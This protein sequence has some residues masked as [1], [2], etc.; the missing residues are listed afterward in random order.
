MFDEW[1]IRRLDLLLASS[2]ARLPEALW[3]MVS[4]AVG[5]VTSVV[6]ID[7]VMT[8]EWTKSDRYRREFRKINVIITNTLSKAN[9]N[10]K[11]IN[12]DNTNTVFDLMSHNTN[13]VRVLI[14]LVDL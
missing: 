2:G 3:V 4:V 7:P 10:K 8:L 9:V 14:L 12:W 13:C 6:T 1:L 5:S 11:R